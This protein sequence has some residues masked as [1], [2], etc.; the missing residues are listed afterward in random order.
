[1]DVEF[2]GLDFGDM[3]IERA[4]AVLLFSSWYLGPLGED[5][6][7]VPT[8]P[9]PAQGCYPAPCSEGTQWTGCLMAACC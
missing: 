3:L 4:I 8:I 6:R 2:L 7:S 5:E 1:M 9:R